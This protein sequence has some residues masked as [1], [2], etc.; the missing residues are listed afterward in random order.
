MKKA[1]ARLVVVKSMVV[2]GPD[3]FCPIRPRP[4]QNKP[5]ATAT[6]CTMAHLMKEKNDVTL[7]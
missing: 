4:R 2:K 7:K 5:I 3:G 6:A 1:P